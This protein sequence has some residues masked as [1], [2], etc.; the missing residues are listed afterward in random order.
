MKWL[1]KF[2]AIA[3]PNYLCLVIISAFIVESITI[4][5]S[6]DLHCI[7]E[8]S[9]IDEHLSFSLLNRFGGLRWRGLL[10]LNFI[11]RTELPPCTNVSAKH[12]P[13][14]IAN[15]LL[16]AVLL[17]SAMFVRCVMMNMQR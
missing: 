16:S 4:N 11:R 2:I 6:P 12:D 17:S 10:A 3:Y 7:K 5:F 1:F 8:I 14:A 15:P 9:C 13:P